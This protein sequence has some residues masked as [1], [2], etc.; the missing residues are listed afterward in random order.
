MSHSYYGP[1]TVGTNAKQTFTFDFDT[2]SSDTFIPGP[3]CQGCF[4]NTKYNQQGVDEHNTT[5]VTYGSGQVS[6]ENYLDS[7]TVAGLTATNQNVISLT[8]ATGFSGPNNALMGM[9]FPSIASSKSTPYFFNLIKQS[10]VNP[11][12]FS[13]YL[14]RAKSNTQARS[15]MTLGGRDSS[16][17]TGAFTNVPVTSQTYW[18]TAIDGASVGNNAVIPGTSGQSAIGTF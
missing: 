4:G 13:F 14:G 1:G 8:Q 3:N 10:K 17:Y 12:E 2:G 6:G 16:R 18:Q 5:T 7:V 9:A 15:E 11:P